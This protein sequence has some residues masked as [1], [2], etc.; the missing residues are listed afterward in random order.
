MK[1]LVLGLLTLVLAAGL[2]ASCQQRKAPERDAGPAAAKVAGPAVKGPERLILALG[3]SL[4]AGYG[5]P[6]EQAYPM[7]LEAALRAK[8]INARVINAGVSGDTS[9]D[10]L[11]RLGFSLGSLPRKPDLVLISLGGNDMLRGLPADQ[12]RANLDA[13]LA[14]LEKRQ[15]RVVVMGMLAAPNLG[16]DYAGAFNAVFPAVTKAHGATLVPFFLEAVVDRPDL[17]LAD[18][19]HPT[20]AG[21]EAMVGDTVGRVEGRLR[22]G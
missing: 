10:G 3:D 13:M 17:R 12:M 18:R 4:F 7:R 5:L 9:A 11:A 21:V 8:G 6:P 14:E 15:V 20:A 2:L 19:M 22:A 16:K 1:A